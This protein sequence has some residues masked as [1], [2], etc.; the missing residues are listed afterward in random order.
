MM[1]P[2]LTALDWSVLALCALG[3]LLVGLGD[4]LLLCGAFALG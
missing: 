2:D 3:S 4:V 1:P